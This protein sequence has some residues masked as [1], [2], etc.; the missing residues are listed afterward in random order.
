M[1]KP[2]FL[3]VGGQ[4]SKLTVDATSSWFFRASSASRKFTLQGTLDYVK[5]DLHVVQSI[6][7]V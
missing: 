4:G 6:P 7:L 1:G 5:P 2:S 3:L